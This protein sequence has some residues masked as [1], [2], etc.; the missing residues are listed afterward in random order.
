LD[1]QSGRTVIRELPNP[2]E[3]QRKIREGLLRGE[4]QPE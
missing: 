4:T 2:T 1:Q 3:Q